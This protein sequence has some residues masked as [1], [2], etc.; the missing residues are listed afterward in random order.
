MNFKFLLLIV[1]AAAAVFV[2]LSFKSGCGL[3]SRAAVKELIDNGAL[4]VDVR[5]PEEYAAGHYENSV[6]IPLGE[7]ESKIDLFGSKDN[8][9][10]V[11]CRTGNR[12]EKAKIILER[13][14][15]KNV[16]NGGGLK[17]MQF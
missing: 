11:Y 10:V 6:N 5:T 7:L 1:T 12:S 4:V 8:N 15:F 17:D 3:D 13:Y 16:T 14:G 2:F 9:I